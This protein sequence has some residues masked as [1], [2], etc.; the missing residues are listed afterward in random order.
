VLGEAARALLLTP[1]ALLPAGCAVARHLGRGMRP[2]ERFLIG[3]ALAPLALGAPALALALGTGMPVGTCF[4][5]AELLAITAALWPLGLRRAPADA[6]PLPERGR[7]FPAVAALGTAV[8]LAVLVAIPPMVNPYVRTWSDAWFHSAIVL[9]IAR[10]GVPPGDPYFGGI[11]LYYFWFPHFVLALVT[12]GSAVSPFH[13]QAMMNVWAGTVMA[14]SAAHLAY[15]LFGRP[16][17]GWAGAVAVLG[18][19]PLGWLF[20]LAKGLTG[21]NQGLAVIAGNLAGMNG[22]AGSLAWGFPWL[23]ASMLNRLWS[24]TPQ[25]PALA[26]ALALAWSLAR[27]IE[28]PALTGWLRSG[29]LAMAALLFHPLV[30]L[31]AAA[32]CGAGLLLASLPRE[33]RGAAAA[34]LVTLALAGAAFLPYLRATTA[35][36]TGGVAR[37]GLY[38]PNVWS[39]ALAIGP[40]WLVS[41]PAWRAAWK[42]GPSGRF[43]IGALGGAIL[44]SL[45]LLLPVMNTEKCFYLVWLLLAPLAAGGGMAWAARF[46]RPALARRALFTALLLPSSAAFVAGVAMEHRSAGVLVRGEG[47]STDSLPL[48]TREESQAH[49][50][51]RSQT[52]SDAVVID[53]PRPTVNEPLPVL[54]ERRAFGGPLDVYLTIYQRGRGAPVS[55]EQQAL[56]DEFLVRRA[57]QRALFEARAL[58]EAER[59]YLANFELPLYLMLRRPEL[60]AEVWNAYVGDDAWEP[61]FGNEEVR[62]Y[63]HRAGNGGI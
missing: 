25:T 36:G 41:A 28:R 61:V 17:A 21:E 33:R 13:A 44:L 57:I 37:L 7:G 27:G 54:A 11:P 59:R 9:E 51:L 14:L 48:E 63:R 31:M 46:P 40:W 43:V 29:A 16:A 34:S 47:P 23:H 5:L 10:N 15:R 49:R 55:S 60:A 38:T 22:A 24:G 6:E 12:R 8:G 4:W 53:S 50:F 42:H 2:T 1:L 52:P 62:L 20:C 56:L 35:P 19:N 30:G 26:L 3:L 18:L 39:L 45:A 58:T 32:A